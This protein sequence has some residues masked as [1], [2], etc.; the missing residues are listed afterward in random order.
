MQLPVRRARALVVA[1]AIS[2]G[3]LVPAS[4]AT[5]VVA[6]A[7]N[8]A[9]WTAIV[10]FASGDSITI[11]RS[12]DQILV[13]GAACGIAPLVATVTNTDT[14]SVAGVAMG[15]ESLTID[16]S[17]GALSPGV[18][19]ESTGTSEIELPAV[20]LGDGADSLAIVGSSGADVMAFSAGG[21]DLNGDG[22]PDVTFAGGGAAAIESYTVDGGAGNDAV[23]GTGF[24]QALVLNG[25]TGDDTLTGSGGNDTLSGGEGNDAMSGGPGNDQMTGA[26]GTDSAS[27]ASAS[28]GVAVD[29][30]VSGPQ[31]TAGAGTDTLAAIETL[32]GSAFADELA[33]GDSADSLTGGAGSDRLVGR[34]GDDTLAGGAGIDTIDY[35]EALAA[36]M[37]DLAAGTAS[38]GEGADTLAGSENV[39][40]SA[41]GDTLI[42]DA[43]VNVL[44]GGL[45]P[46]SLEGRD[47]DDTLDGGGDLDTAVYGAARGPVRV[48]LG[49]GTSSGDGDDIL[50]SIERAVGSAFGDR[51]LG[52]S[53]RNDLN[54]GPG[55]DRLFGRLGGDRLMGDVGNDLLR[56]AVGADLLIGNA[57]DDRL[58]GGPGPDRCRGG[59]GR[60]SVAGCER[61]AGRPSP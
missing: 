9:T 43:N 22:D 61:R 3:L 58:R 49:A 53:E 56:G 13:N 17:G 34:L 39:V 44:S 7:Y 52:S 28:T 47:G 16:L 21:I 14:V 12:G 24:A 27:Y 60:D 31:N 4:P 2:L 25:S 20:D 29:L 26:A 42:G 59:P 32:I 8:P 41:L 18:T 54:G 30:A 51:L 50:A 35:S 5:A 48:D 1:G 19:A 10:T 40:G 15:N 6:C 33:G 36:V 23:S 45:G 57:G 55:A 38:G 11:A 46:D 37:V